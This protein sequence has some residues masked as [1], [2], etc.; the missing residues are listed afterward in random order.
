M[1]KRITPLILL[2][3]FAATL[4][5]NGGNDPVVTL[6]SGKK[7]TWKDYQLYKKLRSDDYDMELESMSNDDFIPFEVAA[8]NNSTGAWS[9]VIQMPLVAS[10]AANLPDGRIMTWSA[11]DKLSFGGNLGRTWTAIFDPSSNSAADVLISNTQHDMFCPGVSTLPD[12]RIM[13]SG[14]S[15]SDRSSIYDPGTGQWNTGDLMNIARGYHANTTLASGA[16]FVIGGSWSGG[17]GGK[18]AEVWTEKTGWYR[19]PGVPVSTITDGIVSNQPVQQ[20]DYFPWLFTAPNGQLFHAGPSPQ[21]H[22]I[23]ASG[24]GS[25]TSAGTRGS[26]TYATIGTAVMYDIGK[27]LTAGGNQ[28]FEANTPASNRSFSININGNNAV[29]SET[30]NLNFARNYHSS[31]VLPTG[32][33][34][35]IGGI[36]ESDVFS[37]NNSILVPEL[38]NPNTGQWTQLAAMAV[39]RNYH[40]ISMLMLDGRVYTAGGGLCGGCSTNHPDAEIYSPPYLFNANGSLATRPVL[41]S[42]PNNTGWNTLINVSANSSISNFSLVRMSATTHSTNNELRRIPLAKTN[43]GNNQYSLS[44]PNRNIVPPG[45]YMLFAMNGNGTPS[46]AKI[47]KIGDDINDCTPMTNPNLGGTGLEGKYYNTTNF[48]SLALTRTDATVGFNWNTGSPG[49]NVNINNFSVRWTGQIEVPRDGTY[50]FYTN[51]DDG[52]RLWV[53]GR[54]MV[55]NWTDHGPTEDIGL[56]T[57][58]AGQRYDILLEYYEAGG[59]AVMELRWSGPGVNKEIIP[60]QYLF[61]PNSNPCGGNTGPCNDGDACT[62]NDAYDSN[63]NCVGTLADDDNDGICNADD[64]CPGFNDSLIGT[65][66]DDGNPNTNNDIYQTD[67]NCA[68]TPVNNTPDCNDIGITTTPGAIVVSAVDG[69]PVT[70]VQIFSSTWATVYTCFADCNS[71]I[72]SVNVPNGDYFVFVKYYTASYDLVC[73]KDGSYTVGGGAC[74]DNDNDGICAAQ[75]CDDNDANF[76]KPAGTTCDDGNAN[77]ENDVIQSDGCACA[78]TPIGGGGDC[79]DI[80]IT[81]GDGTIT[82]TGLSTPITQLQVFDPQWSTVLSCSGNNCGPTNTLNNLS[83]GTYFVKSRLYTASWD[84]ICEKEEYVA[85]TGGG[86]GCTDI[87]NDGVCAN[88][89]CDDN[90]ADFPKPAGT[91]CD[92]GNANTENDVIQSDGCTCQGTPIGGGGDC[93]N[94]VFSVQANEITIEGLNSTPISLLQVYNGSWQQVYRCAG[95]CDATVVLNNMADDTYFVSVKLLTAQWGEVCIKDAYVTTGP[96]GGINRLDPRAFKVYPNPTDDEVFINLSEYEGLAGDVII[97]NSIGQMMATKTQGEADHNIVR[98]DTQDLR[99]GLYFIT[100]QLEGRKL[101]SER[102]IITR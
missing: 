18:D 78:G 30:S 8:I 41:N 56:I 64:Q 86:T 99:A 69:A 77:T 97:Y 38:W 24:I 52:V 10:A 44:I 22:W 53:N 62:I 98:F 59:G 26:D 68:G 85:V 11:K 67:C 6:C 87:D 60:A 48:N 79:N 92:D 66:C 33:V 20:D 102:L 45:S 29:A 43:L 51:S 70:S 88:V 36:P 2:C 89:D 95:D 17:V 46:V 42:V 39:P 5:A 71:P 96:N 80:I 13:V 101:K 1:I 72:E 83:A 7:M 90:N 19:L 58:N 84:F 91:S 74:P 15:S 61:P 63:C 54:Q 12:G 94:V 57:L 35:V 93:D 16:T 49:G 100:L 4:F 76:P 3:F 75:D 73:S 55:E 28:T 65:S 40:S 14:G 34:M 21:M 9:S 37:D 25:V 32:E 81:P 31:V 47:I 23:D 50:S 27:I 82:V